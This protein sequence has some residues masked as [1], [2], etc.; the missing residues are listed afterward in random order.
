MRRLKMLIWKEWKAQY[1]VT[2]LAGFIRLYMIQNDRLTCP[3]LVEGRRH[4]VQAL[5]DR[6]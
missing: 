3:E 5:K 6:A 1:V 4:D 2:A